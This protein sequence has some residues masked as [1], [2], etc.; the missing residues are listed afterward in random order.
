MSE[1]GIVSEAGAVRFERLLPGPIERVWAYLTE[2][3]KRGTWLAAGPMELRV[4]GP[5]KLNF[6]HAD[7]SAEKTLPERYKK[8]E[9]GHTMQGRITRCDPPRLLSYT[10][11]EWGEVTF[12]LTPRGDDVLL[13]LTH[14]RLADRAGMVSVAGGWHAHLGILADNLDGRE[15][16]PFWSTH[17]QAAAEYEKR[18]A[19]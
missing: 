13:V 6:H 18:I 10:W 3:Q 16:R 12:E 8:L 5:V 2:P 11:G 7:L 19:S 9:G 4:G 17:A 1:Y 14:Q 15:P